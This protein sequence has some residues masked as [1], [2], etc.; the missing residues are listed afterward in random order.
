MKVSNVSVKFGGITALE[1]VSIDIQKGIIFGLIGPNGAGKTTLF[2][3]ISRLYD[4]NEGDIL[5][6]EKSILRLP[7]YKVCA[8]GIGRT[9]QNLALFKSMSVLYNVMVGGHHHTKSDYISNALKLSWARQEDRLLRKE[10]MELLQYLNLS[11]LAQTPVSILPFGMQKRVEL[12][13]AL[14][15]R[16]KLL[17]LDEPAGGLNHDE[18]SQLMILI[19]KIQKEK[20]LTILIV[21]HHMRLVMQISDRVA[22]LNFGQKIADGTP[23]AI[24]KDP[25]VIDAYLGTG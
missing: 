15:T 8:I 19:R 21:E 18:I 23:E 2:N 7:T 12:A 24:Q 11:E 14:A 25:E 9:F 22:V 4:I 13:R 17:L 5:F 10:A 1:R 20:N 6:E 16:P 3:C